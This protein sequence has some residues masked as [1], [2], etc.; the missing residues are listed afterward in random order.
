[1]SQIAQ[2]AGALGLLILALGV[3]AGAAVMPFVMAYLDREIEFDLAQTRHADLVTRRKDPPLLKQQ[4]E[5][6]IADMAASGLVTAASDDEALLKAEQQIRAVLD[7]RQ[8]PLTNWSVLPVSEIRGLRTFRVEVA[9]VVPS[10]SVLATLS[11][12]EDG[13]PT[14]FFERIAVRRQGAGSAPGGGRADEQTEVSGT[15]RLLVVTPDSMTRPR[16]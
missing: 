15:V 10:S 16:S 13:R 11:A 8:S 4:F 5:S 9:F 2:R 7:R 6:L 14:V 1:M 3:F 12:L